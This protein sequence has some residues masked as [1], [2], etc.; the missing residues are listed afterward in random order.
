MEGKSQMKIMNIV[1]A[2]NDAPTA[3]VDN[4]IIVDED[5]EVTIDVLANDSTSD[6]NIGIDTIY[7][8]TAQSGTTTKVGNTKVLYTPQTGFT[9]VDDF[10]YVMIDSQ[11][12]TNSAQV[13]INVTQ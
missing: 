13:K 1:N 2:V 6:G 3:I 8:Y 5:S 9:G 11:G 4:D 10:W 7:A 12:R